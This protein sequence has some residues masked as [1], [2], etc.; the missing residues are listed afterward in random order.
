MSRERSKSKLT[1]A[2]IIPLMPFPQLGFRDYLCKF[3]GRE[4]I[5][6]VSD[7][8][9]NSA[10]PGNVHLV[11]SKCKSCGKRAILNGEGLCTLIP[12]KSG[13]HHR[14]RDCNLKGEEIT[15]S[16]INENYYALDKDEKVNVY[17]DC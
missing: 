5:Y 17:P 15:P 6:S 2:G 3:C 7:D 14:H 16:Y 4:L 11:C 12:C 8:H 13:R 1:I 10:M 9:E